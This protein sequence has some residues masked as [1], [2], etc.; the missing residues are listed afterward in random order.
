M[1]MVSEFGEQIIDFMLCG[2]FPMDLKK[3]ISKKDV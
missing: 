1:K 2:A 3:N